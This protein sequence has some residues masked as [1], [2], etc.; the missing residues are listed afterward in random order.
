MQINSIIRP[1]KINKINIINK[2]NE[3]DITYET[4]HDIANVLNSYFVNI[5]KHIYE[6]MN[7]GPP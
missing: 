5:G 1:N 3:N 4:K 6:S 2:I 7:P